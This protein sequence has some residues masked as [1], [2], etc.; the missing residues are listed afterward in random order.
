MPLD[1]LVVAATAADLDRGLGMLTE[2]GAVGV[3]VERADWDRYYR[4]AAVVQVG[5]AGRVVVLDPLTLDDLEPL[6]RFLAART[7]VFHAIEN[8]LVP[9]AARGVEPPRVDDT[10]IAAAMLGLP[11]G[12]SAL[13]EQV[14]GI[15]LEADKQAMQRADWE[16]RPLPAEMIAYAAADV[17]DLPALWSALAERLHARER[18]DWYAQELDATLAAPP[19][20][21]RR[22]WTRVKGVGRLRSDARARV[23]ALWSAREELARRTDTAPGRIAADRLLLELATQPPRSAGELGRRGMRRQAVRRFGHELL[24]AMQRASTDDLPPAR[25]GRAP[26]EE[27]RRR[28]DR[29]RALRATRAAELGIDPGVL[30]PSRTLLGAVTADPSTAAE[31]RDGLGLRPWQW[32]QL[33][34]AFCEALGLDA[35][36]GGRGAS[37]PAPVGRHTV[38]ADPTSGAHDM[39]D[40][41]NPDAVDTGLNQL[42]GWDGTT[43]RL[44][45]TFEFDDFAGSIAFV[46]RVAGIAEDMNHHPDIHISWNRVDLEVTSHSAGG[47]TE[48]CLELAGRIEAE[49]T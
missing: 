46:N 25:D 14:L 5:G 13:L 41:L 34:D 19:V 3:D 6:Q 42:E 8:D 28:A 36:D 49:A 47:V 40:L 35:R 15:Q 12:L 1:H 29:L 10:A 44:H 23:R 21:E 38:E 33:G 26:S 9:L 32:E 2:L 48:Q 31:L 4:T 24:E 30:C 27:D 7:S 20:E 18:W 17:A 45:K 39:A 16:A 37:T 11:T 43:E 22:A